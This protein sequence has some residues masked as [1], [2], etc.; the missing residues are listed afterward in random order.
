[1]VVGKGGATLGDGGIGEVGGGSYWF[2]GRG[3][4]WAS[5]GSNIT[6]LPTQIFTFS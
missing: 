4:V 1:M 5:E 6:L 3:F 2:R